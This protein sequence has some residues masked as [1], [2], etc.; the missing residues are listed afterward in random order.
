M[1]DR[2]DERIAFLRNQ[3]AG[4]KQWIA[5]H[6]ET[7]AGYITRYGSRI[8]VDRYG[9][10]GEAIY[11]ADTAALAKW[12]A[13]LAREGGAS[14]TAGVSPKKGL[15]A[16]TQTRVENAIKHKAEE[17]R[18]TAVDVLHMMR[19]G[20]TAALSTN[21]RQLNAMTAELSM[22]QGMREG[23]IESREGGG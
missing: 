22:L 7:L 12:E 3:I 5:E 1:R 2:K 10:G 4:Q 9:D 18:A 19:D 8:D 21:V 17:I 20:R 14:S 13:T 11:D 23:I 6:G 16:S 15:A